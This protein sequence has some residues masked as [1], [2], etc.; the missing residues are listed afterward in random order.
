MSSYSVKNLLE[1]EPEGDGDG[2][3]LRFARK[4]LDSE[5]LGVSYELKQW[6]VVRVGSRGSPRLRRRSRR[7]DPDRGRWP[8]ARGQR[9]PPGREPLVRLTVR[10]GFSAPARG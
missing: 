9:R 4:Y 2:S 1:I 6:D 10:P 3:Q 5:E 8:Q 7:P